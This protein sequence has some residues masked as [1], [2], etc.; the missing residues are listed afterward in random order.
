M[1]H[2]KGHKRRGI[3]LVMVAFGLVVLMGM[4]ALTVDVGRTALAVQRVQSVA[5]A[6]AMAAALQLP[7]TASANTSLLAAL[8]ANN[9]TGS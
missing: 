4:A 3:V 8:A 1:W 9:G 2:S 5:D 7:D 6:T